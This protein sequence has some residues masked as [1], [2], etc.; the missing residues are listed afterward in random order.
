M[1]RD[2]NEIIYKINCLS[3]EID[4]IYHQASLKL[5]VSDSVMIILYM[6][7]EGDGECALNKIQKET[8]I[9]KQ[10]LNSS[11]RKLEKD[12]IIYLEQI[13][14]KTKNVCFTDK[15]REFAKNNVI[16]LYNAEC[17]S[18]DDWS[19]EEIELYLSLMK[20]HNHDLKVNFEKL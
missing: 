12:G 3:S 20:R 4:S 9:S 15:G 10:T 8:G 16:R 5:G 11:I 7:F 18:F 17:S 14:G 19:D 2:Y 6:I 13:D 1:E